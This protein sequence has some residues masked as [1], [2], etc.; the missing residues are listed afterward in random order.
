MKIIHI[1]TI[2]LLFL[3]LALPI[4]AVNIIKD[5]DIY[6]SNNINRDYAKLGDELTIKLSTPSNVKIK[7]VLVW[8]ELATITKT[9]T[10]NSINYDIKLPITTIPKSQDIILEFIPD[11]NL[12]NYQLTKIGRAHV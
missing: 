12:P 2:S 10:D 8:G 5:F 9:V 6:S 4:K 11:V 1:V 7:K 3:F